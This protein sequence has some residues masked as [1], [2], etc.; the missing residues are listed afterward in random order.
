MGKYMQ[1]NLGKDETVLY[2]A[3]VSWAMLVPHIILMLVFIG[4]ITIIIAIVRNITTE[5]GFTNKK[6][7]GKRG[8]IR[9]IVMDA[10]LNKIN[11]VLVTSGLWGKIC[12]FGTVAVTTSSGSYMFKAISRPN[13]FRAAL[14]NQIDQFDDDRVKK[15]AEEM[16]RAMK[17]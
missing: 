3:K 6:L 10:P 2:E 16:A 7:L 4:F 13:E 11:N 5:L 12:N 14:M 8:L 15:Q 1:S 9:T 17:Q